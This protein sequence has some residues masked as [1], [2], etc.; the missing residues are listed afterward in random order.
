MFVSFT[1]EVLI[2]AGYLT[3]MYLYE[4][5]NM[6]AIT[7]CTECLLCNSIRID[8]IA[9]KWCIIGY[10]LPFF[11]SMEMTL[12]HI[13]SSE[14]HYQFGNSHD[15]HVSFQFRVSDIKTSTKNEQK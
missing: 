6:N 1:T 13:R 5:I 2:E 10:C 7:V 11:F 3:C 4:V 14:I 9:H 8:Y 12:N 15:Q